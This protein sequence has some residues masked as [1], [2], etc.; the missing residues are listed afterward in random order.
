MEAH[1]N[2]DITTSIAM[3]VR[4]MNEVMNEGDPAFN[5]I[6]GTREA[7]AQYFLLYS[8]SGDPDDFDK[9]VDFPYQHAQVTARIDDTSTTISRNVVDY[10]QQYLNDHPDSPFTIVGGFADLLSELVRQVVRGQILSL[11][12]S[13][14]LVALLVALLFRSLM[15]GLLAA[16]PLALAMALLFGL[17]GYLGIELNIPT[18]MLSS[19]MIGVGVDYTIHFLWR[20]RQERRAGL[21]PAAAVTTTLVT[22][23]R[24]I[25]FNALSVVIGFSVLMIS[26]FF[27]IRFFGILVVV[28]ISAC[29]IGALVVLPAIALIFRPR[30]LEPVA[31]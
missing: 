9:L 7:I 16:T 25:V 17:M 8:M 4:E 23:G 31:E 18:A 12:L 6:P 28:S 15:A 13:M 29:L 30:F 21:N 10:A 2:V 24:G 27:P 22:S 11:L 19:I 5:K 14:V 1:P 26:A 3:V 20:Y